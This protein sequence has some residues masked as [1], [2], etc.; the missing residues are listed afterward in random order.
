M[1]NVVSIKYSRRLADKIEQLRQIE[2]LANSD[3][4]G[5]FRRRNSSLPRDSRLQMVRLEA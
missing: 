4:L 2:L 5:H 3:S 1:P